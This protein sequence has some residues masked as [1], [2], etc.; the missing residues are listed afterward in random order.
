MELKHYLGA[1]WK[2]LWLIVLA[3]AIAAAFSYWSSIR[4]PRVYTASTTLMVGRFTES[5][6]PSAQDFWTSQ[7]LAASYVQLVRRQP[8]LEATINALQLDTSWTSLAGRVNA[9]LITGTQLMQISVADTNPQRAAAIADEIARQMILQ[10]PTTPEKEQQQHRQYV[11][12]QLTDLQGKMD[13]AKKQVSDLEKRLALE[14]GARNIQDT[15]N[16]IGALQQKISAWQGNYASLLNFYQGSQTNYLSVVDA[17]IVPGA[18]VSP[19]VRLNVLLAAALGCLLAIGAAIVLE[20]LDDTLKS[21]EE[22]EQALKLATLGNISRIQAIQTP[23]EQLVALHH[24]RASVTEA[25][26]VLRTNLQFSNLSGASARWL[27]TSASPGEGKTTTAANLAIV[28]AQ[29]G[30][31]VILV[32]TDLRRP[33]LHRL[34]DLSNRLGLTNLLLDPSLS[35]DNALY[36]IPVAGLPS[37]NAGLWVLLS[38]PLPPIPAE[39]LGSEPMKALLDQM[40]ARADVLILDSPPALAVADATILGASCNGVILVVDSRRTR[41]E[42]IR[43]AKAVLDQVGLKVLGVI[44]NKVQARQQGSYYYYYSQAG[45]DEPNRRRRP[46]SSSGRASGRFHLP[47]PFRSGQAQAAQALVEPYESRKVENSS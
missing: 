3:T 4:L 21:P 12:Q 23:G 47:F 7:Q 35:L 25:Y 42:A 6:S 29:A 46:P 8:I 33:S 40:Q 1:M 26:R 18:P 38:G 19:N 43:R 27:V 41:T 15:Q 5:A 32:D 36:E 9:A 20:Y 16:Q 24:P 2:W 30:K 45:S 39:L 34:F 13:D 14:T 44:L 11:S 31:R 10:S 37:A 17:A 22:V 28:L